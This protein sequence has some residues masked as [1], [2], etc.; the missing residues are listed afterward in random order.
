[1]R[2]FHPSFCGSAFRQS[3]DCARFNS[4]AT[5]APGRYSTIDS[6]SSR[7]IH[8]NQNIGVGCVHPNTQDLTAKLDD[9]TGK[10]QE[11]P[12]HAVYPDFAKIIHEKTVESAPYLFQ[13]AYGLAPD[14]KSAG[15]K[16]V[17]ELQVDN[18][19]FQ[20]SLLRQ[21]PTI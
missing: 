9:N 18:S 14:G 8:Y 1:M 6:P 4:S 19:R 20:G 11:K 7:N 16:A 13:L 12:I 17:Q 15:Q 3:Q 10:L 2:P 5:I 21:C